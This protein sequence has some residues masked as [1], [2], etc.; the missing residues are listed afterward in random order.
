LHVFVKVNMRSEMIVNLTRQGKELTDWVGHSFASSKPGRPAM[1]ALEATPSSAGRVVLFTPSGKQQPGCS[2]ITNE[3]SLSLFRHH[4]RLLQMRESFAHFR[5]P[6][7]FWD[8]LH[9][10][11]VRAA[12]RNVTS[13]SRLQFQRY[14]VPVDAKR[15]RGYAAD[16]ARRMP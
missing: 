6:A 3:A 5:D 13:A 9:I 2:H 16:R 8:G 14:P 11:L 12:R 4:R 10:I 1:A 7:H 15:G